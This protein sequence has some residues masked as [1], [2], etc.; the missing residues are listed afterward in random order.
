MSE[1]E[2]EEFSANETET[3]APLNSSWETTRV[4]SIQEV[5]DAEIESKRLELLRA[6]D[7]IDVSLVLND[8]ELSKQLR[9]ITHECGK[10][11]LEVAWLERDL[12]E[13]KEQGRRHLLDVQTALQAKKLEL[14]DSVHAGEGK[15][16]T[17]HRKLAEQRDQIAQ[18]M[19]G[20]RGRLANSSDEQAAEVNELHAQ[21]DT[22]RRQ[23]YQADRKFE[24]DM[25]EAKDTIEM[26]TL[27]IRRI[28]NREPA[29][30]RSLEKQ[31]Q[32]ME[33]LQ[34]KLASADKLADNLRE[35]V[36]RLNGTRLEMRD[37]LARCDQ[38]DW[39]TRVQSLMLLE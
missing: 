38:E 17:L 15:V 14:K 23:L 18:G 25:S 4:T 30:N 21:I 6:R 16:Q 11:R 13:V 35:R 10:L 20:A 33:A 28:T 19:I 32:E 37:K 31:R 8:V 26:L 24:D 22:V 39:S 34:E 9:A 27:E 7:E 36:R 12:S 1:E 29:L 2:E 3:L 5:R